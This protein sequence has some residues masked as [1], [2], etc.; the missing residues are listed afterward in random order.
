MARYCR[1]YTVS[2]LGNCRNV[3]CVSLDFTSQISNTS[4]IVLYC[5][6]DAVCYF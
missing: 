1:F 5:S 3:I 4:G 2:F 6:F